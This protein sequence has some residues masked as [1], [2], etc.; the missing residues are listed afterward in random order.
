MKREIGID[1]GGT[2]TD[3]VWRQDDGAI[4][5]KKLAPTPKQPSR[6]ASAA[7]HQFKSD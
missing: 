2:F 5:I 3:I 6:A 4:G 1:I 7:V